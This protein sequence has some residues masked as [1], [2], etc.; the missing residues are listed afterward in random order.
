MKRQDETGVLWWL[1]PPLHW[2]GI[3][4]VSATWDSGWKRRMD[5]FGILHFVGDICI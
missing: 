5:R 3:D 2:D 4:G 1:S